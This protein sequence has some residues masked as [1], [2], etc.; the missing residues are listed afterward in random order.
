MN[1]QNLQRTLRRALFKCFFNNPR[2]PE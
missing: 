2:H 1:T